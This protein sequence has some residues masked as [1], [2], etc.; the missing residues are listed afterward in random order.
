MQFIGEFILE[1]NHINV[2]YVAGALLEMHTL[3]FIGEFILERNH[4]NVI[5]VARL[6][7]ILETLQFIEEV[8]LEGEAWHAAVSGVAKS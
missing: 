1:R 4:V 2:I 5:C 6:L 3:G 8:I 7:V